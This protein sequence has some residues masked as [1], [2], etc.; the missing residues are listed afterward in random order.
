MIIFTIIDDD[1]GTINTCNEAGEL[2]SFNDQPSVITKDGTKYWHQYGE[3]HRGNDLPAIT[4][5]NGYEAYF[6][7]GKL[8]RGNNLPAIKDVCGLRWYY[9]KD[10]VEYFPE[11]KDQ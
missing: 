5:A 9:Y 8:H 6:N 7:Y 11:N 3:L 1:D 4:E 2:H 10:G